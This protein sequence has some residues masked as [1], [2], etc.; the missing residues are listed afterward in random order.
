MRQI[1]AKNSE[2]NEEADELASQVQKQNDEMDEL[3]DQLI[4]GSFSA[5]NMERLRKAEEAAE[6]FK[7]DARVAELN[8]TKLQNEI[9]RLNTD[10]ERL[11]SRIEDLNG[12]IAELEM[13]CSSRGSNSS[14]CNSPTYQKGRRRN[15]HSSVYN[16]KRDLD[17]DCD[18]TDTD[19]PSVTPTPPPIVAAAAAA[20]VVEAECR[21]CAELRNRIRDLSLD[22]VSRNNKIT[23]LEVQ[24]QQ[25]N[26]PY[27]LKCNELREQLLAAKSKVIDHCWIWS[28]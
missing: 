25:E 12:A 14:K 22:L 28:F 11:H 13:R 18:S 8:A 10:K 19:S 3:R 1:E 5:A 24:L 17:R 7:I 6:R 2:L 26:F 4:T 9:I 23:M 15:R 27:Q 20:P 21:T 16:Q